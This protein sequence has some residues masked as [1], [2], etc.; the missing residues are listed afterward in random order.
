MLALECKD[1]CKSFSNK[2]KIDKN[3]FRLEITNLSIY[4][5]KVYVIL[6]PNGSGKTTFLKIILDLIKA[7]TGLIKIFGVDNKDNSSR[8]T[9]GYLPEDFSFPPNFTFSEVMY[10]FGLIKNGN[11]V[12]LNYDVSEIISNLDL[13]LLKK[14]KIHELS[15]GMLQS[16]AL[17]HALIGENKLLILDEPFNGLDPLQK[18]KIMNY[19]LTL[20]SK[21]ETTI[22][23][24]THILGD[25]Q[26][27]CDEIILFNKGRIIK[28]MNTFSILK[29][30]NSFEEFYKAQI[31]NT[32]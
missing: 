28:Q 21:T 1:I 15:K 27:Y 4:P 24:T 19:L 9:I 6:G 2:S 30:N 25:I 14:K 29:S 26:K 32:P 5:S 7:D 22:I 18:E 13:D 10:Y 17:A 8:S 23:I 20:K 3:I 31:E 16:L 11:A 12:K